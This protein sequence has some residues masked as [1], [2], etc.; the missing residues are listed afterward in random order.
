M[1]KLFKIPAREKL[2]YAKLSAPDSF[3]AEYAQIRAE[4]KEQIAA[5]EVGGTEE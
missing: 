2:G 4:M 1:N 5:L 3:E